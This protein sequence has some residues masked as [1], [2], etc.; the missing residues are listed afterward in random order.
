V[1]SRP[2]RGTY[3]TI[4]ALPSRPELRTVPVEWDQAA[5]RELGEVAEAL[6]GM[7]NGFRVYLR[8]TAGLERALCAIAR[9]IDDAAP[10]SGRFRSTR[11]C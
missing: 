3:G 10:P 9:A 1:Q 6:H 7:D 2:Q 8:G 5:T 11:D 4:E